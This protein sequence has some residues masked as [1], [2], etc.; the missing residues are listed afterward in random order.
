MHKSKILAGLGLLFVL[1]SCG[2]SQTEETCHSG[3]CT[4]NSINAPVGPQPEEVVENYDDN[5]LNPRRENLRFPAFNTG[6]GLSR[7]IYEKAVAWH[8]RNQS[9]LNNPRYATIIDFSKYSSRR[10]MF[11]F[12]LSTGKMETHNVAHGKN[13]DP[14]N[15]GLATQFSNTPGSK[16]SSLGVY[17]TSTTYIGGKGYSMR[18]DGL[19]ASNSNARSRA[20]VVHPADYVS[21]SG[22]AGR[23][24]GCPALDPKI[25]RNVIDR[26]K[27]GSMLVIGK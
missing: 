16:M 3:P 18:L 6:W 26:I 7:A 13:S 24:W 2:K 19:E 14:D 20:I 21:D 22:R 15:D 4:E 10:R 27:N 17:K 25:S 12:D 1:S 8:S 11:L 23:S 9:K 5:P